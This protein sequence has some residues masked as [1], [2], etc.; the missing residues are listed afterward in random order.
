MPAQMQG[1]DLDYRITIQ[2]ATVAV[3]GDYGEPIETWSDLVTIWAKRHDAS[4]GEAYRAAE[5]SAQISVHFTVRY[6]T[7]TN[8]ITPKDRILFNGDLYNITAKRE[9]L[10]TRRQWIEIDAVARADK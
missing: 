7:V 9:P 5:V 1:G 8:S 4:A 2:R 10:G 3:A 6:S